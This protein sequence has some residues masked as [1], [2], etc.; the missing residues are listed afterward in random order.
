VNNRRLWFF[1][2]L[3]AVCL[4]ATMLIWIFIYGPFQQTTGSTNKQVVK[5]SLFIFIWIATVTLA[6]K[7]L[8]IKP[9]FGVSI[10]LGVCW[11]LTISIACLLVYAL[12]YVVVLGFPLAYDELFVP[13]VFILVLP[14]PIVM[15]S[16]VFLFFI[17]TLSR[18]K[19]K[20]LII[21]PKS[22][23]NR[24]LVQARRHPLLFHEFH[25][26]FVF[27]NEI[28]TTRELQTV[29]DI[30]QRHPV[31]IVG[32]VSNSLNWE[33][34][35][36]IRKYCQ[37][38]GIGF[39]LIVPVD[40]QTFRTTKHDLIGQFRVLPVEAL[41]YSFIHRL[42]KRIIDIICSLFALCV[43]SLLLPFIALAV[44]LDSRGPVFFRQRRIGKNGRRFIMT[45]LRSMCLDAEKKKSELLAY[46]E[47]T[48]P[49]FKMKHDPRITR[50]G[51]FLRKTSLDEFPQFWN[52]LL[53]E[54]SL[55]G[56]RPPT[57][58][59]FEQYTVSD[60]RRL[61]I[62]P[63]LTGL[64]QVKGRRRVVD[65]KEVVKLDTFYIEHWSLW[66]DLKIIIMTFVTIFKGV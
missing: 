53:G 7:K 41:G 38:A 9:T 3:T 52:V 13:A 11:S 22:V 4:I 31:D 32:A 65:F 46:N 57:P 51:R 39:E 45:K 19:V 10:F 33:C 61:C 14:L 25:A 23:A 66:L 43:F 63:G 58:D 1:Q 64:W 59:E 16:V 49:L 54:M 30:L 34:L 17:H 48:G 50:V 42:G 47:M 37:E 44:K 6:R 28:P 5:I 12:C 27:E 20:I 62:N 2:S 24:F 29:S 56:T 40:Q 8:P 21:G 60:R 55:V 26:P 15:L 36:P 35:E 18:I